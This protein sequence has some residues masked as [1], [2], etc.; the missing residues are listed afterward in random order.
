MHRRKENKRMN[1][2]IPIEECQVN[3]L[4]CY[5]SLQSFKLICKIILN[6]YSELVSNA[7]KTSLTYNA[8]VWSIK[9]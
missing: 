7:V 8:R 2:V 3:L 9:S 4:Y 6:E 5:F 1:A